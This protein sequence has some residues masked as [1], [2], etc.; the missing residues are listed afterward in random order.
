MEPSKTKNMVAVIG[1]GY[2]GLTT[3]ACLAEFGHEVVGIETSKERLEVLK[4]GRAP[5]FEKNLDG[6]IEKGVSAG[7]LSF[8]ETLESPE[9]VGVA[10]VCVPTPSSEDGSANLTMVRSVIERLSTQLSPESV[11]VLKS[12]VPVGTNAQVKRWMGRDDVYLVSNPEFLQAGRAVETF[13]NPDRVVI[14]AENEEAGTQ[15]AALYTGMDVT[16]VRTDP[17]SAELI[18]YASNTYLA[19]RLSFVNT[20]ATLCEKGGGDA[21]S[22][23]HAMGLDTRIGPAFLSPGPGWGGSCFPKDTRALAEVARSIGADATLLEASLLANELRF[24]QVVALI[25]EA[26]GGDLSGKHIGVLGL[27]FKA[28][29]DGLRESPALAIVEGLIAQGA[30][31]TAYDPMVDKSPLKGVE[32]FSSPLEATQGAVVTVV[33]TEWPE[34]AEMPL[35]ELARTMGKNVLVDARGII[36]ARACA[37]AGIKLHSVGKS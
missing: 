31:V 34:F 37:D 1:C 9:R 5:F 17:Q 3:A 13:Q 18:K 4:D 22:V 19:L 32:V 24:E 8:A 23:L 27:A 11:I 28:G 2:V 36:S 30:T 35:G 10:F 25:N 20:M 21:T 26:A 33:L 7:L 16:I 15:V 14:G 12:T 6:L 29:T